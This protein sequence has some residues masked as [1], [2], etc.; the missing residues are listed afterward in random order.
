M[1]QFVAPNHCL[2]GANSLQ[3]NEQGDLDWGTGHDTIGSSLKR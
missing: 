1:R 3:K 2:H